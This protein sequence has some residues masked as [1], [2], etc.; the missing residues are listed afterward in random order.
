M[1]KEHFHLNKQHTLELIPENN[2]SLDE[3]INYVIQTKEIQ[4]SF[5]ANKPK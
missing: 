5:K 2:L 1:M 3:L 4:V